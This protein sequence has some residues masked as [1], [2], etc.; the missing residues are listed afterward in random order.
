[1]S[2]ATA[3]LEGFVGG[4]NCNCSMFSLSLSLFLLGNLQDNTHEVPVLHMV[5]IKKDHVFKH[6]LSYTHIW[7][8]IVNVV[9][10]G[11]L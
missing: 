1:M 5:H 9:D 8:K 4:V 6:S 3:K 10:T 7:L 11:R 2:T